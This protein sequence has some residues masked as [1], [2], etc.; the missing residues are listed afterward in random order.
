[1]NRLE[2][3]TSSRRVEA[4]FDLMMTYKDHTIPC[5]ADLAVDIEAQMKQQLL[6]DYLRRLTDGTRN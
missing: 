1:M 2:T 6:T 5:L 3:T 4:L